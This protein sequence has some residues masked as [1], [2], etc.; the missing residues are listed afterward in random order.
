M[1]DTHYHFDFIDPS[2]REA[3]ASELASRNITLIAQ[4]L[5]PSSY[6]EFAKDWGGH[7]RVLPAIGFH[8]WHIAAGTY[9]AELEIFA[10]QIG[11]VRFVGEIGLDYTE[12]RLATADRD[13]QRD[14]FRQ[15][16]TLAAAAAGQDPRV[17]SIHTVRSASDA[18][19]ILDEVGGNLVPIF[20]RF[21]GTSDELTRIITAGGYISIHP[22]MTTTKKGRAYISQVPSDRLLLETD[23]PHETGK[24][25]AASHAHD[26]EQALT[27]ILVYLESAGIDNPDIA[28]A[29]H[30]PGHDTTTC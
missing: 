25:P 23:L 14:V 27:Q 13:L 10:E 17:L 9:E 8:P 30:L 18:L 15:V 20:H 5:T 3:M 26:L 24:R 28:R 4:T 19:D 11:S 22:V 16:L 1:I 12:S 29:T 7:S 21:N 6:V 2:Q